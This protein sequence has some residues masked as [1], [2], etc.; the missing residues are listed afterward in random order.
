MDVN[1]KMGYQASFDFQHLPHSSHVSPK[2]FSC[3][4]VGTGAEA[5]DDSY[6]TLS[7]VTSTLNPEW[8]AL[9]GVAELLA[10]PDGRPGYPGDTTNRWF[11]G[12]T[13]HSSYCYAARNDCTVRYCRELV[14]TNEQPDG[15]DDSKEVN[16]AMH[17]Q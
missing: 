12:P 8:L 2:S 17:S 4:P 7:K 5:P 1:S 10:Q 14:V 11:S 6:C 15:E 9:S 13:T 3:M 16:E